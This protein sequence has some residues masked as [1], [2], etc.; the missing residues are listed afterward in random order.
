M[1]KALNSISESIYSTNKYLR[2]ACSDTSCLLRC[3]G[4]YEVWNILKYYELIWNLFELRPPECYQQN[5]GDD[6]DEGVYLSSRN[7]SKT[8]G[9]GHRCSI[10]VRV[11]TRLFS[12]SILKEEAMNAECCW[13]LN[14]L[15]P[16][17]RKRL[18]PFTFFHMLLLNVF[19]L[20]VSTS[21]LSVHQSNT[22]KRQWN[23]AR[24]LSICQ[25]SMWPK[26]I[27]AKKL[28]QLTAVACTWSHKTVSFNFILFDYHF[29]V[30][31]FSP[32]FIRQ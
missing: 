29:V 27:I 18:F 16:S 28:C 2:T 30:L 14:Y 5:D 1:H 19:D 12:S 25:V 8:Q 24:F 15:D 6:A 4:P 17:C 26:E 21:H 20:F 13:V 7:M 32:C 22:F 9:P 23:A 31:K 11:S 3:F 10:H